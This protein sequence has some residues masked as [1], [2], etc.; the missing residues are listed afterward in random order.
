MPDLSLRRWLGDVFKKVT[1]KGRGTTRS[2][3]PVW[4]G[5]LERPPVILPDKGGKHNGIY[6]KKYADG[7]QVR[8]AA[9]RR[10]HS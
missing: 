8:F 6:T 10:T 5:S 2:R 4:M 3:S 9:R 1:P 7:R